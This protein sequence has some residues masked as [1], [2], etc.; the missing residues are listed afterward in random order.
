MHPVVM[1]LRGM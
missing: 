1:L